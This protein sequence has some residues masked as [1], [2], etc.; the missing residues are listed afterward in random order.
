M[1]EISDSR[2][3]NFLSKFPLLRSN[4]RPI[5]VLWPISNLHISN[6]GADSYM[7]IRMCISSVH[8]RPSILDDD[9]PGSS[10]NSL[11]RNTLFRFL[12]AN[13][14][15]TSA[16]IPQGCFHRGKSRAMC[17]WVGQLK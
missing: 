15:T 6:V 16:S 10:V 14:S 9:V 2:G 11:F 5:S 12:V 8:T 13:A 3:G 4:Y 17:G 1:R 7:A